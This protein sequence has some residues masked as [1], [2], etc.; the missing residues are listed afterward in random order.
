MNDNSS[1]L[2]ISIITVTLNAANFLPGLIESLRSQTCKDFEWIV[3]DGVSTDGTLA[4]LSEI[5]DLKISIV[6]EPDFG[7][8]DAMNRAIK[9]CNNSH[10]LIIGADDFL[11]P[12]A[13]EKILNDLNIDASLD[14]IVGQV[15]TNGKLL[16]IKKG[17]KS[18]FGAKSLVTAHSVGCVFKKELHSKFGYYSNS[19]S[20]LADTFFIKKIFND[21]K[22]IYKYTNN[23]H[24][25]FSSGGISNNSVLKSYCEFLHIQLITERFQFFQIILFVLRFIK[26]K[27]S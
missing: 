21:K 11:Y 13:V 7:I 8:Y 12:D 3:N 10:Y 1:S 19:Y 23:I 25:N 14:L 26:F 20:I 22:L 6:S 2:K 15:I 4:L 16:K 24:G 27:L 18:I 5:K 9:R 17:F